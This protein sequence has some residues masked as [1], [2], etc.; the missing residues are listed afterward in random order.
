MKELANK[1]T[2]SAIQ[3]MLYFADGNSSNICST[4]CFFLSKYDQLLLED[5]FFKFNKKI[6]EGG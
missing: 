6:G 3:R 2:T 1:V 4:I 5:T